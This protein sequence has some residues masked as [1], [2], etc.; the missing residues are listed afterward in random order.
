MINVLVADDDP[1]TLEALVAC[2]KS[3]GYQ[4][5]QARDGAEALKQW[6]AHKPDLCCLDI[7]MPKVD[8]YEV[9]RQIRAENK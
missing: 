6:K 4:A 1:V 9:C 3:E 2:L 7:M 5:L 8:G